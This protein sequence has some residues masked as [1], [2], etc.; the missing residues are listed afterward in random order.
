MPDTNPAG[1]FYEANILEWWKINAG[2]FPNLAWMARDIL[3]VQGGSVGIERVFS[4]ARDVVPYRR[5]RLKSSTIRASMLVKSYEH[6]ELRRELA[7]YDSER[8]AERLEEEA[9]L[10]DYRD[11]A[12]RQEQRNEDEY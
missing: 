2:R 5:S 1:I 3:A 8:E 4:M 9:S 6:E 12:D 7:N 10:E 11:T